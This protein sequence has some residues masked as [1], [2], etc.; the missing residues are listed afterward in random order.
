MVQFSA[1]EG[2]FYSRFMREI[3]EVN[4]THNQSVGTCIE[5]LAKKNPTHIAL[6][7]QD[8]SWTWYAFNEESN[9]IANYFLKLGI[10]PTDSVA[11]MLKNSPEYLFITCA[12]NKI[13]GISGLINFNQKKQALIHSFEKVDPKLIVV[14]GENLPSFSEI[15]EQLPYKNNQIFVVNN[16]KDIPHDFI[17]LPSELKSESRANPTTTTN[18]TLDQVA[19]YVFSSGTTGLPK[20]IMMKHKKLFTQGLFLGKVLANL[21]PEDVVYIATPLYHNLAIGQSWMASVLSGAAAA[22]TKRFSATEFWKEIQK[23]HATYVAYVG[24]MPRYLLNQPPS[25]YEGNTPL[26][27]MVGVGLRKETWEQFKARFHI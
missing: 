4:K 3:E 19:Y 22:L 10:N 15:F 17:E 21:T 18:S 8:N 25:E 14:D 9:K 16:K 23:Y 27:Y 13:Q 2:E 1:K 6:L 20:A 26:K 11:L 7:F 12:V 5:R 24:E